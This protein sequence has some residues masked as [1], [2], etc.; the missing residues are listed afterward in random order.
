MWRI[1]NGACC[2]YVPALGAMCGP[3]IPIR[4]PI[5][6][7]RMIH[8]VRISGPNKNTIPKLIIL[9]AGMYWKRNRK[10]YIFRYFF[11]YFDR[12]KWKICLLNIRIFSIWDLYHRAHSFLLFST[13][14][15]SQMRWR[16]NGNERDHKYSQNLLHDSWPAW[17]ILLFKLLMH[18]KKC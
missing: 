10:V 9:F 8:S 7:L 5:F 1:K 18:L 3:H 14:Y 6:L 12:K 15:V 4:Y 11:H 2:W 16:F 17:P 13:W